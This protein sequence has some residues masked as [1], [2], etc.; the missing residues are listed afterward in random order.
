[1]R[2]QRALSSGS[3]KRRCRG[4]GGVV[5]ERC[6]RQAG[7]RLREGAPLSGSVVVEGG[8]LC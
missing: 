6:L 8:S 3:G 5:R 7:G 2:E 4:G 1:M